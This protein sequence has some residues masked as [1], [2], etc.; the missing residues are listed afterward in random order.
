MLYVF[1]PR[2]DL[3]IKLISTIIGALE[4][5]FAI[6]FGILFDKYTNKSF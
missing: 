4:F 1:I 6:I 5:A 3:N 2:P